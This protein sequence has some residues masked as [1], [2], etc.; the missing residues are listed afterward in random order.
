[1]GHRRS[2]ADRSWPPVA[3]AYRQVAELIYGLLI[4]ATALRAAAPA[5][6]AVGVRP[7]RADPPRYAGQELCRDRADVEQLLRASFP[8]ERRQLLDGEAPALAPLVCEANPLTLSEGDQPPSVKSWR[9]KIRASS[10]IFDN[11][12]HVYSAHRSENHCHA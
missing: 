5:A 3:G 7:R 9:M 11:D 8:Y 4:K 6:H 10:I 1:M 2:S 12:S